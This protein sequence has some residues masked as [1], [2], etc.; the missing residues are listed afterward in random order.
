MT[1]QLISKMLQTPNR[2]NVC[3]TSLLKLID[4]PISTLRLI[5]IRNTI[6]LRIQGNK[7]QRATCDIS[8]NSI[9]LKLFSFI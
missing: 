7:C 8:P 2:A 9:F 4:T 1:I 6:R 5:H 3:V